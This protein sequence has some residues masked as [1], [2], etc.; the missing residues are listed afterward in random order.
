MKA[1]FILVTCFDSYP[2]SFNSP[3]IVL[4]AHG[5]VPMTLAGTSPQNMLL[6]VVNILFQ[7]EKVIKL[8]A[9]VEGVPV[10]ICF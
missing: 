10:L 4:H 9:M 7:T 5:F 2:Y 8:D 3:K 1:I 6:K